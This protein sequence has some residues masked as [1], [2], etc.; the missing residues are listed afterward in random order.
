MKVDLR[1]GFLIALSCAVACLLLVSFFLLKT[2]KPFSAV[3]PNGL[4]NR[5]ALFW[6]PKDMGVK[7]GLCPFNCYLPD[8]AKGLCRVRMN[9][10]GK[11]YTQVFGQVVSVNLD[12]I[13]KKPVY[14]MLPGTGILSVSTVGCPL[15][16]SFCQNWTISQAYPEQ[17]REPSLM[18]PEDLVNAALQRRIP[19]IAY[20]YGE[21]V[22]YFEYMLQTAR[23]ARQ[24]GLRNVMVTSGFINPAPLERLAP[25]MDVVKVDLKGMSEKFYEKEVGGYLRPVLDALKLLKKLGVLVEVVNLVVPERNDTP[26]DFERL[27]RWVVENLGADCPLF[28]SRFHPD[29]RMLN[30]PPTPLKTLELARDISMKNGLQYVYLG[31]VPGH[32]GE[33][34]YCPHDRTLLIERS[35]YQVLQ[36][37]LKKGRCPVCGGK[38]PGIWN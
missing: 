1:E 5:P 38:I 15:R 11:L 32:E 19:S 3:K 17:N 22:A 34:T 29:Y 4:Y 27:S 10:N 28:F 31:N 7:C 16:C 26:E 20:T 25:Y 9:R 30:L 12:P 8:G 24:K 14:H 2:G 18:S 35:G 6:E 23:L 37:K 33:N 21:P 36:N 13:E